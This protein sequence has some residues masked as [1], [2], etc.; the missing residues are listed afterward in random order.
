MIWAGERRS[1]RTN[2]SECEKEE[3]DE[4]VEEEEPKCER[5]KKKTATTTTNVY[6]DIEFVHSLTNTIANLVVWGP[7]RW[8]STRWALIAAVNQN[9][10]SHTHTSL[11]H[12]PD[13]RP[14]FRRIIKTFAMRSYVRSFV[15]GSSDAIGTAFGVYVRDG[16]FSV[17]SILRFKTFWHR[18]H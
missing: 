6:A 16:L 14:L 1:E 12:T 9:T 5:Q 18:A 11:L 3:E 13:F 8:V 15:I 2:V 10:R 17:P 7:L 4:V